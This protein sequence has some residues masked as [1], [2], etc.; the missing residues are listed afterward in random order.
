MQKTYA[1]LVLIAMMTVAA[2]PLT[3]GDYRGE[4]LKRLDAIEKKIVDLAGA[5]PADKYTWRPGEDVRSVSEVYLH[6]AAANYG[7]P[8][9][10]GTPPPEGFSFGGYDKQTTDKAEILP[11]VKASFAHLRGAIEKLAVG[12]ADKAVKLF[13]AG[14]DQPRGVAGNLGAPQ[15]AS[16]PVDRLRAD[17]RGCSSVERGRLERISGCFDSVRSRRHGG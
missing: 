5:V 7:I 12:D 17:Q 13:G 11:K 10:I 4:A 15:R 9:S 8:G 1:C 16:G 2:L 6:I 14:H 3:A